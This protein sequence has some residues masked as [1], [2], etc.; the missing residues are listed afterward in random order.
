VPG[1][2]REVSSISLDPDGCMVRGSS[3]HYCFVTILLHEITGAKAKPGGDV[4]ELHGKK[5]TLFITGEVFPLDKDLLMGAVCVTAML[6][7]KRK[8]E[9]P[10]KMYNCENWKAQTRL[11]FV[12]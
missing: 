3:G 5:G 6:I 4:M 2:Q 8:P 11:L 7:V 10:H 9:I 12:V 1:A